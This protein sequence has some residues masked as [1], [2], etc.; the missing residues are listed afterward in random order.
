MNDHRK[1]FFGTSEINVDL[2]PEGAWSEN[3]LNHFRSLM[4]KFGPTSGQISSDTRGIE[5]QIVLAFLAGALASGFFEKLGSDAYEYLRNELKK[6]LRRDSDHEEDET[7]GRLSFSYRDTEIELYAYYTCLYSSEKD[8]DV[9]FTSLYGIDFLI[10]SACRKSQFPFNKGTAFD[11][12]AI[13]EFAENPRWNI[14]IRRHETENGRLVLNEFF[15]ADLDVNK[16]K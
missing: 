9:L 5:L 12:H 4:G 11:V 16:L 7:D 10:V 14:R 6:L 3:E 8:L 1:S 13:L 2:W 15:S